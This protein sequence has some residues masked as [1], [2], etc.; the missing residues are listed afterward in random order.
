MKNF[1]LATDLPIATLFRERGVADFLSACRFVQ[2]LPYGRISDRTKLTLVLSENRGTCSSKHGLLAALA[3]ESGDRGAAA[4][5]E[6]DIELIA[7]MFLMSGDTHPA[8][9]DLFSGK[10]FKTIPECH[11]YLRY[12][13][14]RYDYTT[15]KDAMKRIAPKIVREQRIEPH[16]VVEWKEMIH[17]NYVEG[18]LRRNPEFG[19]SLEEVWSFREACIQQLSTKSE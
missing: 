6:P 10:P 12:N 14:E 19:T 8:L 5:G 13:G 16:Q 17:R 18:W 3:E 1:P 11:C 2:E 7:G 4:E 15:T 9:T